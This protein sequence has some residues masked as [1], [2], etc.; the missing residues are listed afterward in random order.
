MYSMPAAYNTI[1][2]PAFSSLR[3]NRSSGYSELSPP[4]AVV[5]FNTS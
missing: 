3:V 2:P 5:L 4:S 1:G